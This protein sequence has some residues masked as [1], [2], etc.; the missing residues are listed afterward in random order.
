MT[1]LRKDLAYAIRMMRNSPGFTAVAVLSLALGIG[2]NTAIFTLIDAVMLRLLPVKDPQS[3]VLLNE[4]GSGGMSVGIATGDRALY[5][6]PEYVQLRDRNTVLAGLTAVQSVVDRASIAIGPQG[7]REPANFKMVSGNFFDVLGVSPAMGRFFGPAED[8]APGAHPLAVITYDYWKRRFGLSPSALGQTLSIYG[9]VFTIVGVGPQGFSGDAVGENPDIWLPLN[10]QRQVIP[11]RDFL[12]QPAGTVQ[13]VMWL[14]LV[15][16]LRPGVDRAQ[17]KTALN[18]VFRQVLEADAG[19]NPGAE[20]RRNVTDTRIE[21]YAGARGMSGL[22]RQFAEPLLVL[23]SVVGLVL[24]IA[25]ANLA[26]LLLARSA[27]REREIGIRLALGA[28]RMR[29]VRQLMTESVLLAFTGGVVGVFFAYWAA[30]LLLVM[31]ARGDNPIALEVTPDLRLMAFAF[32]VSLLTGLLFGIF[33]A[34]RTTR[35]DVNPVLKDNSRGVISSGGHGLKFS[36]GKS[37]VAFQVGLS[38]VLL[39]GAGLFARSLSNLANVRLGYDAERLLMIP[40]DPTPHGY[41]GQKA[42]QLYER[43]LERVSALPG[44]RSVSVSQNGLFSGSESGDAISVE[45]Y[46]STNRR[47]LNARF[48]QVGPLYFRTVG[49]P[50]LLGREFTPRDGP[51][52]PRVCLINETMAKFYFGKTNPIG[53]HITDEFPDTR[54][55]FEIVGVVKDAKY[56]SVREE[57]PRRF[58]IPFFHPLGPISFGNLMIRTNADPASVT[59]SVRNEIRAID[60]RLA[61]DRARTVA[62]QIDSSLVQDRLIAQLSMF[63]GLLALLLACLGL[64]GVMSYAMA[65]RTPEIGIRIALGAESGEVLRMVLRESMLMVGVGA[66]LGVPAAI[67]LSQLVASRLYGLKAA[68]PATLVAATCILVAVALAAA[69]VPA[70]RA[71]RVDPI[72][73]LRC[74]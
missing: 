29:L 70:R 73:A 11:G 15:G 44:V 1:T 54:T 26:N 47:D 13:K 23:M 22:R 61:V 9:T 35:V 64:Y 31:A 39:I 10:M 53:K 7:A 49:I 41:A 17:A 37:L 3:I 65:R 71:S 43:I 52:S 56:L 14:R 36:L 16:R 5:S 38:L 30:R 25:C 67:G 6:Y 19:P 2:A 42:A 60:D 69:L 8:R 40:M 74:E 28:G 33:P 63:F 32:G 24:L 66:V 59:A 50:V 18:V 57:T 20:M 46:T 55:T 51:S 4:P 48:D 62:Q 58:Y 12:V 72:R 68:D 34:L 21:L 27:A 45:G